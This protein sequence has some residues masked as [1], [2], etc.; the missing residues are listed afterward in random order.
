MIIHVNVEVIKVGQN[1][2]ALDAVNGPQ[3]VLYLMLVLADGGVVP[4]VPLGRGD[5]ALHRQRCLRQM[6][7][8]QLGLVGLG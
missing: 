6:L 4:S 8:S 5:R 1:S 7:K 2:G 3:I